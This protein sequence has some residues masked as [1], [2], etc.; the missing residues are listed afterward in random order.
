M[1]ATILE[2][3]VN[4]CD[5]AYK[6]WKYIP[7]AKDKPF[8]PTLY[9]ICE[10]DKLE[11]VGKG[12]KT[13]FG[14]CEDQERLLLSSSLLKGEFAYLFD[15][16]SHLFIWWGLG[17]V[18]F[19]KQWRAFPIAD[20][21]FQDFDRPTLPVTVIKQRE[22]VPSFSKHFHNFTKQALVAAS[23]K[24]HNS[25]LYHIKGTIKNQSI[26][27][28]TVSCRCDSLNR[29]DVYVLT[30]AEK[31][32][33]LWRGSSSNADERDQGL[34]LAKSFACQKGLQVSILDQGKDDFTANA[35]DFWKHLLPGKIKEA[36]QCDDTGVSF[37]PTVFKVCLGQTLR[38]VARDFDR[39]SR[40]M[41]TSEDIYLLDT[42][43]RVFLWWGLLS[44]GVDFD[45]W[46]SFS[47]ANQYFR[48][49]KRP[50]LPITIVLEGSS[51]PA[52]FEQ[53]FQPIRPT[54]GSCCCNIS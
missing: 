49:Y 34:D 53:H 16:G 23:N 38:E 48:D 26:R 36:D 2:E 19:D 52:K 8:T 1:D 50:T 10:N 17:T 14:D 18:G 39:F 46:K 4:D 20:Q 44:E 3:G 22:E 27:I 13:P 47:L 32:V 45:R 5:K 43:F 51:E 35:T 25:V 54:R 6:F 31:Y 37:V 7:S 11:E 33:W 41:L 21:Y 28:S 29:G 15:T 42:G 12:S 24:D 40:L 30:T 9:K